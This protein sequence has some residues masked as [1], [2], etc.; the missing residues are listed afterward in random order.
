MKLFFM[1]LFGWSFLIAC[2]SGMMSPKSQSSKVQVKD[3]WVRAVPPV[4]KTSA[5]YMIL[6]NHDAQKDRLIA[7]ESPDA[8]FVQM[9]NVLPKGK[10]MEMHPVDEMLLP[11]KEELALKPG[12]FHIM[13]INLKHPL[14][15]GAHVHL[16]L[17][18]EKAGRL[19][20]I[21]PVKDA[22]LMQGSTMEHSSMEHSSMGHAP[23]N[24]SPMMH[25]GGMS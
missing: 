12:A 13:L 11:A 3:A 24:D 16:F 8:E 14:R 25:G 17:T 21:V 1:A 5:A 20:V 23:M 2:T 15:A 7:V 18:F 6:Q 19:E 4:S 10:M 9:H 22:S